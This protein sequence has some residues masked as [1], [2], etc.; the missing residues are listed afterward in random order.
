MRC[1]CD[2]MDGDE[3]DGRKLVSCQ[4]ASCGTTVTRGLSVFSQ[5][6]T[7][8]DVTMYMCRTQGAFTPRCCE[9]VSK[10]LVVSVPAVVRALVPFGR[11]LVGFVDP[12]FHSK[13]VPHVVGLH[14]V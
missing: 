6:G 8:P 2:S 5:W 11:G 13:V 14:R 4:M 9:A 10:L 7:W 1:S 3:N 12:L